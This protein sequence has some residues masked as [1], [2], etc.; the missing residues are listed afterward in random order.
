VVKKTI[1][2][3]YIQQ[4]QQQSSADW[5]GFAL[6][7]HLRQH[8]ESAPAAGVHTIA[9]AAPAAGQGAVANVERRAAEHTESVMTVLNMMYQF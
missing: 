2:F 9:V 4:Q 5:R 1:S 6:F 3:I 7:L 8:C